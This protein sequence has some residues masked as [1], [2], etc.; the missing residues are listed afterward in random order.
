MARGFYSWSTTSSANG[1]SDGT[2]NFLEGQ[3]PSSVNDSARALM[4]RLREYGNDVSGAIVTSGDSTHFSLSSNQG[5]DS[6]AH[7]DGQ[8]IAFT[9]HVTNA[10]ATCALNVD[11]LGLCAIRSMPGAILQDGVLIQG[12]PYVAIFS[13]ADNSFYLQGFYG[14]PYNIPLGAGF[15]YW[16]S[17]TP[18]NA[19]A[20]PKGQAISRTTYATLFAAMGTT[21]GTGD[22]STTFN[23]PNKMGRLSAMIEDS[24]INL[25]ATY[26][27]GNSTHLGATG[28]ADHHTLIAN[29]I[30]SI[31]SVNGSSVAVSGTI[32]GTST[33]G[34]NGGN[35]GSGVGGGGA[36]GGGTTGT[37]TGTFSGAMAGGAMVVTSSNTGAQGHTI[38][39]P[40]ICCNY[41][42]R[43]L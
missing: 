6:F 34:F 3:A 30:P 22:G 37:V 18:N 4:A 36:F 2:I 41:I 8:I 16:L 11:S 33:N 13:N 15:D 19:F 7:M 1:N 17:T 32:S 25:T 28:G 14:N 21:Y 35:V 10:G 20:F 39:N 5:F 42:M 27:G 29:E 43:I 31:Q 23:L 38:V 24:S 9:P 12:T 40:I 26:F